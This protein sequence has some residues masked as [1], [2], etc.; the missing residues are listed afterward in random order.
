M[1]K[2]SEYICKC[3][4]VTKQDIKDHVK[5]GVSTYKELRKITKVGEC[6]SCKKR[7]KKKFIKYYEKFN[8]EEGTQ[9]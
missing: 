6:S 9:G 2:K 4:N 5:N 7:T 8:V 1:G 3:H